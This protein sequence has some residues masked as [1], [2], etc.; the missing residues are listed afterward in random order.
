M[1][2]TNFKI[3]D[4]APFFLGVMALVFLLMGF[5]LG[6]PESNFNYEVI[7]IGAI[8][9]VVY[10]IWVA[11]E[12]YLSHHLRYYQKVFWLIVVISVPYFGA[13]IYQLMHQSRNKI[14]T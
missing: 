6:P 1:K 5:I 3:L 7:M 13:L 2:D 4:K 10:W 14:V 11:F 9:S 8:L 12:V